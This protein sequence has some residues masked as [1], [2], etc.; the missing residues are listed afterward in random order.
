[1]KFQYIVD[2]EDTLR[3]SI[4][5]KICIILPRC[6]NTTRDTQLIITFHSSDFIGLKLLVA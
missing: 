5:A 6:K 4:I 2:I 3:I 1:M